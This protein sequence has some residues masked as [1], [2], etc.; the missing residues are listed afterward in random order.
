MQEKEEKL[1]KLYETQQQRAFEKVNRGSA[2]SNGSITTTIQAGK[3]RQMFDERRQKAGIDKSY[4]L[5]PL[6]TTRTNGITKSIPDN[7]NGRSIIKTTI[8]K[9]ITQ[10]KNGKPVVG[11]RQ[12]VQ[13][14]YK[15]NYGD[16]SYEER[17]Y[18]DNNGNNSFYNGHEKNLISLMNDHNLDDSLDNE[19]MPNLIYD[20]T[21]DSLSNYSNNIEKKNLIAKKPETKTFI[22]TNTKPS[23]IVKKEVKV[24]N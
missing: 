21:D 9:N 14:I 7:R 19:E 2:G 17:R 15:N 24:R 10:I 22:K 16:E 12:T 3:V 1:L 4:P 18:E 11:K 23:S 20:E 13:S 5:E 8:Q 6:K